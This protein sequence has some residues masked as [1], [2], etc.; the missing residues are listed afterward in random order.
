M[1]PTSESMDVDTAAVV[2]GAPA[3]SPILRI[4]PSKAA[5]LS[6]C[7]QVDAAAFAPAVTA[8]GTM[9]TGSTGTTGGA[10]PVA[11]TVPVAAVAAP[12]GSAAALSFGARPVQISGQ[13][14]APMAVC[15]TAPPPSVVPMAYTPALFNAATV[16]PA[17]L[18]AAPAA[19]AQPLTQPTAAAAA[20][21][22][23]AAV[24][25]VAAEAAPAV[26]AAAVEGVVHSKKRCR[27][28]GSSDDREVAIAVFAAS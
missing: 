2:A 8:G 9:D 20:A 14:A 6:D 17:A 19:H 10:A 11:A 7:M 15:V 28:P 21:T 12:N 25:V 4:S 23:A 5:M 3:V 24:A 13:S 16:A 1:T 26:I 18:A 27:P 22:L